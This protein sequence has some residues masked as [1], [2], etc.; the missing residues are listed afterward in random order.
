MV[1]ALV[2]VLVAGSLYALGRVD[3]WRG[4]DRVA[5]TPSPR[6]LSVSLPT[7]PAAAPVA[8]PASGTLQ[9]TRVERLLSRDLSADL[10][11]HVLAAVAGTSGAIVAQRGHGA[12]VPAS[13]NK[14]LTAATVLALDG[15]EKRFSTRTVLSDGAGGSTVTLVGGGDPLLATRPAAAG[16]YPRVADLTTLARQTAT[17]LRAAGATRVR[18]RYD[19]SLFSGPAV[20]PSWPHS[21]ITEGVVA[22]ITALWADEG[23]TANGLGR[24]ADPAQ[25]AAQ[26]FAYALAAAGVTVRGAIQEQTAPD[27]ARELAHVDSPP[28]REIVDH[29]LEVSDNE[30]AEVLAHQ[31][32]LASGEGGSFA[33]GVAA[34]RGTLA[35]LGVDTTG[36]V[37]HDGSGLSRANR[38][39]PVTLVGVLQ[40]AT[41]DPRLAPIVSALPVAG[42]SGSLDD[43]FSGGVTAGRGVVRAK[44]GTLTGVDSLA[45]YTQDATGSPVVFAIMADHVAVPDTLAARR[46]L[47]DLATAL[48]MCRCG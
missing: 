22:P 18:L 44:T 20:D 27:G 12:A 17:A 33:G 32:G 4:R 8:T 37:L 29:V 10:G 19:T 35:G 30:G 21:Y 38:V 2:L 26:G 39:S 6:S 41:S 24:V 46:A 5:A 3:H 42:F 7:P 11:H 45:G 31:A 48:T 1:L 28:L 16:S 47:D 34:V 25:S 15:P 9:A 23:R 40:Q 13:T 36:L 43:R 14:L